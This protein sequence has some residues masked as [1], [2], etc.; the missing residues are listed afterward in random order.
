MIPEVARRFAELDLATKMID[1]LTKG[2][3]IVLDGLISPHYTGEGIL[4]EQLLTKAKQKSVSV[5]GFAKTTR[6]MTESGSSAMDALAQCSPG[7]CW[8][9]SH[10]QGKKINTHFVRLHDSSKH[11][12]RIEVPGFCEENI[13]NIL[14]N[15]KA[16]SKDPIFLGYPYGLI[17]VDRL[18][19]VSNREKQYL[20]IALQSVAGKDYHEM[21]QSMKA[22][23][24]HQILDNV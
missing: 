10:N 7:G 11:V 5:I 2:D 21:A 4:V 12:F 6:L 17:A 1:E 18:A 8:R 15:L 3:V 16:I 24:A 23:D 20:K 19:R 22:I 9:Y 13:D 14:S